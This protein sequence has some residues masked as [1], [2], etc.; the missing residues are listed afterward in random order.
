MKNINWIILSIFVVLVVVIGGLVLLMQSNQ[1]SS[2]NIP[3][4]NSP[5]QTNNNPSL[6]PIPTD[7]TSPTTSPTPTQTPIPDQSSPETYNI[8][9]QNF[10]FNPS[11]LTIK[12]GDTVVWTNMDSVSNDV[13]SDTGNELAS[14]SLQ[15]SKTFSHTFNTKGTFTYHCGIHPGMK[16]TIIVQ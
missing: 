3:S 1:N 16:A 15:T 7:S 12:Q 10:A 2:T 13:T 9:I 4:T 5:G 8:N 6:S 14:G 11:T